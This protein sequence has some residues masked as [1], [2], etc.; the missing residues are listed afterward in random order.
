MPEKATYPIRYGGADLNYVDF[1]R[2]KVVVVPVPYEGTVTYRRGTGNGP[3]AI[4]E[5][6][7]NM[8][9]LDEEL[10][11]ETHKVGIHTMPPLDVASLSVGAMIEKVQKIEKDI[12]T[13]GKFPVLVGG[14]HSVSIGAAKAAKDVFGELSILQLDAHYDLRGEYKGSKYSHACV[15]RRLQ[16]IA[17]LVQL[18]MRSFSREEKDFL[19]APNNIA[20]SISAYDILNDSLW[21]K[22]TLE[23]LKEK[24]YITIDLDVLDPSIMPAVGTPEPG[25]LGW[26]LILD[27]L[28]LIA[29]NKEIVG[30]DV[31]ELAPL[32]GNISADF[33][34]SKLIYRLLGYVFFEKNKKR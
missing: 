17:P 1:D 28:R 4:L 10:N 16:E 12:L 19:A 18:G 7:N 5:A 6:S 25:G 32:E 11:I 20:R 9:L 31:V 21:D 8:E 30:F 24:V 23:A 3:S 26:Y 27:V 22:K 13:A 33:L 14:E 2:A 15:G 29:Q 34:A